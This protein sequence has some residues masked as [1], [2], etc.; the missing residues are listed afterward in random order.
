MQFLIHTALNVSSSFI[1]S[2]I[3]AKCSAAEMLNDVL[4]LTVVLVY[5]FWQ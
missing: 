3:S 2:Y 5:L 4:K 1:C